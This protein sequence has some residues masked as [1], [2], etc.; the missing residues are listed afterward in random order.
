M[1][2][3]DK[4]V[5][6]ALLLVIY[7][8]ESRCVFVFESV[9]SKWKLWAYWAAEAVILRVLPSRQRLQFIKSSRLQPVAK[10][11]ADVRIQVS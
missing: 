11:H 8:F 4:L 2:A 9:I 7:F 5:V 6:I 10:V 1:S 3:F